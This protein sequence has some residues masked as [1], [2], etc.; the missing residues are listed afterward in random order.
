MA[1]LQGRDTM[2]KLIISQLRADGFEDAA[3]LVAEKTMH[4][5]LSAPTSR[6]A[7]VTEL[8]TQSEARQQALSTEQRNASQ[9]DVTASSSAGESAH[10]GLGDGPLGELDLESGEA[11]LSAAPPLVPKH[12]YTSNHRAPVRVTCFSNDGKLAASADAAALV[13][14]YDIGKVLKVRDVTGGDATGVARTISDHTMEINDMTFHPSNSHFI[15]SSKDKTI[16]KFICMTGTDSSARGRYS[17]ID[18]Y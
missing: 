12:I 18:C 11:A 14:I 7:Y 6:L 13:R 9:T 15:S 2:Y 16:R 5:K 3:T 1:V 8:G 17:L 4:G 10:S